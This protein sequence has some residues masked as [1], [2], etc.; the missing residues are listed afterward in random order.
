[1]L[2]LEPTCNRYY[3]TDRFL[4]KEV[5][6]LTGGYWFICVVG[7]F[8]EEIDVFARQKS[9]VYPVLKAAVK[10]DYDDS[11]MEDLLKRRYKVLV[12]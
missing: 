9:E 10:R 5:A 6:T 8:G 2:A 11:V 12:A 4:G 7:E 1:M 3:E